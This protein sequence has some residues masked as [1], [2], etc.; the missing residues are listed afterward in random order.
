MDDVE[1]ISDFPFL[2]LYYPEF[3]SSMSK[4]MDDRDKNEAE[5]TDIGDVQANESSVDANSSDVNPADANA[6]DSIDVNPDGQG[7][8]FVAELVSGS[9]AEDL[10]EAESRQALNEPASGQLEAGGQALRFGSPFKTDADLVQLPNHVG[11]S[12]VEQHAGKWPIAEI[13]TGRSWLK[14]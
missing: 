7:E 2:K 6:Q 1:W 8:V 10:D 13:D 9:P 5:G 14:S 4:P 12:P 11:Q 3:Q